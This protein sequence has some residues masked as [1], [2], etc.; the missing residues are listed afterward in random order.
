[1]LHFSLRFAYVNN[2]PVIAKNVLF[3]GD[4]VTEAIEMAIEAI[5][6]Y[7]ESLTAHGEEISTEV[8]TLDYTVTVPAYA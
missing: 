3:Y 4:D 1:M 6:L 8:D 5:A 2:L 7:L